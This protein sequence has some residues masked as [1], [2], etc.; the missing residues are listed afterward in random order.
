MANE[1]RLGKG[2]AVSYD[3]TL[4]QVNAN[5]GGMGVANSNM[6]FPTIPFD[7]LLFSMWTCLPSVPLH[8]SNG[9][10]AYIRFFQLD[11]GTHGHLQ[12]GNMSTAT[13]FFDGTFDTPVNDL[14]SHHL[15]SVDCASQTVQYYLNDQPVS[16]ISGGWTGSG[17]FQASSNANIWDFDIGSGFGFTYPAFADLW[18][19]KTSSFVD[20][21]ISA[22]RRK[23]INSDLTPVDLGADGSLPLGSVPQIFQTILPGGV[24]NDF[25]INRGL[26]IDFGLTSDSTLSFQEAGKCSLPPCVVVD[27]GLIWPITG[28]VSQLGLLAYNHP[29]RAY[30]VSEDGSILAGTADGFDSGG[31]PARWDGGTAALTGLTPDEGVDS[32]IAGLVMSQDGSIIY[33][34]TN[35][36][37]V[38]WSPSGVDL[39]PPLDGFDGCAIG[40]SSGP[41]KGRQ[42]SDD[43]SILF[44]SSTLGGSNVTITQWTDGVPSALPLPIEAASS[45]PNVCSQDGSVVVGQA[46]SEASFWTGGEYFR[47]NPYIGVSS[48]TITAMACNSD[49]SIIYGN[50]AFHVPVYWDNLG[51]SIIDPTLGTIWGDIHVMDELPGTTHFRDT[52]VEYSAD[53]GNI[54]V[55]WGSNSSSV[56]T[57]IR[58]TGTTAEALETPLDWTGAR[59]HACSGDGSIVVGEVTDPEFRTWACY[60]DIDGAIH[61]LP[62]IA[63][64]DDTSQGIA[65]GISRDGTLIFGDGD[66]TCTIPPPPV[67]VSDLSITELSVS[68]EVLIL[69]DHDITLKWSDDAGASWSNGIIKSVGAHGEYLTSPTFYRLGMARSRIFEISWA[70]PQAEAMTGVFV[71]YKLAAS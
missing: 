45:S 27:T 60:W 40:F 12:L 57:A 36:S 25:L 16:I 22:N 52:R 50:T 31:H 8:T 68:T 70:G 24:P 17:H 53:S 63:D 39:F 69:P 61:I 42:C 20:L 5:I 9:G 56:D 6:G 55:G 23:F 18:L 2:L 49:A 37:I 46:E 54:A 59:A 26:G 7:T 3:V 64:P 32:S 51:H 21:S 33:S 62:G 66:N 28:G 38:R 13:F 47:L 30:S 58:W 65:M 1:R 41:L 14:R 10:P 29:T 11:S 44:G 48:N 71:G 19:A 67:P 34:N 35:T 4:V 43:G 15:V